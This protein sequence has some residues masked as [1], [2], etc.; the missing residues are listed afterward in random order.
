MRQWMNIV[1][2]QEDHDPDEDRLNRESAMAKQLQQFCEQNMGWSFERGYSVIVDLDAQEAT[3][4]PDETDVAL[5][6][7][8]KLQPFGEV[9]LSGASEQWALVITIKLHHDI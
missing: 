1:E 7:L 3:L 9:S 6:D 8:L 2:T 4:R 5:T